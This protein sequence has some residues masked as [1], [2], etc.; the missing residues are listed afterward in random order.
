M[1]SL[2]HTLAV[3]GFDCSSGSFLKN[4]TDP[5]LHAVVYKSEHAPMDPRTTSWYQ[6]SELNLL[7]ESAMRSIQRHGYPRQ[8]DLLLPWLDKSLMSMAQH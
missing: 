7:P 4:P 6:L 1:V 5:W 2:I 3:S 8:R